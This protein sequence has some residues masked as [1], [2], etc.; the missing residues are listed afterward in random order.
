[1]SLVTRK[2]DD[3]DDDDD[4]DECCFMD[5]KLRLKRANIYA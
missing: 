4:D 1:M 5:K 2:V 3:D